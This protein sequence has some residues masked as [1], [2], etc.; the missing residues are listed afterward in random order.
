M[1]SIGAADVRI[2]ESVSPATFSQSNAGV[3]VLGDGS[4][5]V[6]WRDDREGAGKIFLQ[7]YNA[8]GVPQGGNFKAAERIDGYNLVEPE[9]VAT[10]SNKFYLAY[11]DEAAGEIRCLRFNANLS[12]DAPEFQ[13]GDPDPGIYSGPYSIDARP[14]GELV[15]A[16]E[17]HGARNDIRLRMFSSAVVALGG[18][19][20]V[21]SDGLNVSHWSP[22]VAWD[23]FGGFAVAW[24]DYRSGAADI[25]LRRYDTTSAALAAEDNLIDLSSRSG[26][27]YLP[28]LVYSQIH[29]YLCAWTDTRNGADIFLQRFSKPP[30][31]ALVGVNV[32]LSAADTAGDSLTTYLDID[33]STDPNGFLGAVYTAYGFSDRTLAQRFD[34]SINTLV[35]PVEINTLK[36]GQ[37][38]NPALVISSAGRYAL[39]WTDVASGLKDVY[40]RVYNGALNPF[41]PVEIKAHDDLSGAVSDQASLTVTT[42][43]REIVAFRDQRNDGGDIFIQSADLA[44]VLVGS[45]VR[46]NQDDFGAWQGQPSVSGNGDNFLVAWLDQRAVGG[47]TG[48]RIFVRYGG[49]FGSFDS[50]EFQLS[51][52]VVAPKA[53]PASALGVVNAALVAWVD[54]RLGAPRIYGRI[55]KADRNPLVGEFPISTAIAGVDQAHLNIATDRLNRFRVSWLERGAEQAT[56]QSKLY[57]L[58]GA[59]LGSASFVS[60]QTGVTLVAFDAAS[61]SSGNFYLLWQGVEADGTRRL[62][63]SARDVNGASR[64]PTIEVTDNAFAGPTDPTVSVDAEGFVLTAWIDRRGPTRRLFTQLYA[65]S[66]IPQ[67]SNQPVSL[68]A[69]PSMFAPVALAARGRSWFAWHDARSGGSNV[70]L[71]GYVHSTTDVGDDGALLPEHFALQQN[72]PN[73]FNPTTQI[74]FTLPRSERVTLMVYNIAGQK[75]RLLID[76]KL[77]SGLHT[78]EWNGRDDRGSSVSSG[79]YLYRLSGAKLSAARKMTLLK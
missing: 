78:I 3:C 54:F 8:L 61:D 75:V 68:A 33:L 38:Q 18:P 4:I 35:G 69:A 77:S 72:Y 19:V 13:I 53:T 57:G 2:S 23:E 34:G 14:T 28:S 17:A 52:S 79:I 45:N 76:E 46:A 58:A 32:E 9:V 31:G 7:K 47:I 65:S 64:A 11:R 60:D 30:G 29:G 62:F 56:I 39:C 22:S 20:T 15:V 12:I 5:I 37:P 10:V 50:N 44:P 43:L 36:P 70:Y 21:N 16:Y 49:R 73:P 71:T 51:G 63:L 24:E 25:Y 26:N 41:L 74:S 55:L 59:L 40:F 1:S 67:G 6:V 27:Q 66:L 48:S 42:A